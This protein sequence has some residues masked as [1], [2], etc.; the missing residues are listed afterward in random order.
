MVQL[1]C[2]SVTLLIGHIFLRHSADSLSEGVSAISNPTL[3]AFTNVLS[4]ELK[5]ISSPST[6]TAKDTLL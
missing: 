4:K 3:E 2:F 5:V 6:E 1:T